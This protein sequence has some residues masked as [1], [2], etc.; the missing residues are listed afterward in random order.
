MAYTH[1]A[2]DCVIGKNVI[3]ANATQLAGH[4]TI[5]DHCFIGGMSA[6]TQFCRV[7]RYCYVGGVSTLRKDLPPFLLGKGNDFEVQGVNQIGLSRQGFSS[8]TILSIKR[9]FKIFYLQN[10]TTTEAEDKILSEIGETDEV[11]VFLDFIH[12]TH[13]GITR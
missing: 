4:V 13:S 7:G 2:H 3:I 9:L 10:L 5:E 11:K 6:I 8:E 12:S 1:V